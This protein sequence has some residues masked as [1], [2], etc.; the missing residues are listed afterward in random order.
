MQVE[1]FSLILAVLF[2]LKDRVLFKKRKQTKIP[3]LRDGAK[4]K[5]VNESDR[6]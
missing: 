5:R 3:W 2:C 4:T 1:I 6:K